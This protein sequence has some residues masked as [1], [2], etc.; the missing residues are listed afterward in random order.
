MKDVP[1]IHR[2]MSAA[3]VLAWHR[4][5]AG[6]TNFTIEFMD[7]YEADKFQKRM[8]ISAWWHEFPMKLKRR[9]SQVTI[10]LEPNCATE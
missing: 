8:T 5:S 3:T 1:T 9:K 10:I 2:R 6:E 4:I 7:A